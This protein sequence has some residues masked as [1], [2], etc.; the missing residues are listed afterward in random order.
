MKTREAW[1]PNSSAFLSSGGA[2]PGPKEGRFGT[3][4][5]L[6]KRLSLDASIMPGLFSYCAC[7]RKNAA[8]SGTVN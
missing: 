4:Q 7:K 5:A 8:L 6:A 1:D 3:A 2:A